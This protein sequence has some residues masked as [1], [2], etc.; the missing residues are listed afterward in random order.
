MENGSKIIIDIDNTLWDLSPELWNHL[1]KIN[2]DM[3]PP[4]QWNRWESWE[5]HIPLKDLMRALRT[6]HMNQERYPPYPESRYFLNA[7][8]ERDFHIIIASHRHKE[9]LDPT[10][11]WLNKHGL[12]FDE[13]H[14]SYDKSVLFDHSAGIVDDNPRVLEKAEQAGIVRAGLLNPWNEDTHHPLFK[15]L[16]EILEFLDAKFGYVAKISRRKSFL[17]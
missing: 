8:K 2:P 17:P 10:V 6:I 11:R 14:L 3:P 13:V 12:V 1:C 5:G 7:L 9:T 4:S 16:I 15:N